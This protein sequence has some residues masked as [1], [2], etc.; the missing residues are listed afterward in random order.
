[1]RGAETAGRLVR[2]AQQTQAAAAS[3]EAAGAMQAG[4]FA[5]SASAAAATATGASAASSSASATS[6]ASSLS[7]LATNL[8]NVS[9]PYTISL[10]LSHTD[11]RCHLIKDTWSYMMQGLLAIVSFGTLL[12]KWQCEAEKRR[13]KIFFLDSS[14][15]IA[16]GCLVHVSYSN[17]WLPY[18]VRRFAYLLCC[19]GIP[20][21]LEC[22]F[23][24][25]SHILI[26][27][28]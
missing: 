1:M 3:G 12:V 5:T 4:E 17:L 21:I 27:K 11:Q 6:S 20:C 15:Q 18:W 2:T 22:I 24:L 13:F 25:L 9:L 16:G 19:I 23:V 7:A 10:V 14:K 28:I 26:S 8:L